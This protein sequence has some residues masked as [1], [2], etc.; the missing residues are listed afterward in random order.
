MS[1]QFDDR[2]FGSAARIGDT[3]TCPTAWLP[4]TVWWSGGDGWKFRA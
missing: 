1:F 2:A 4:L 3:L